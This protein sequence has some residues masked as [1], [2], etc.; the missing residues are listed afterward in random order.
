MKRSD[1]SIAILDHYGQPLLEDTYKPLSIATTVISP[2]VAY[3][4]GIPPIRLGDSTTGADV[5]GQLRGGR[6]GGLIEL[7]DQSLPRFQAQLD[8]FSQ[9]LSE[10]F[11]TAGLTLFTDINGVVPADLPTTASIGYANQ[12]Q[13]SQTIRDDPRLLRDGDDATSAECRRQHAAAQHRR[14]RP[15][16][17][18]NVPDRRPGPNSNLTSSLPASTDFASFATEL[19][20]YQVNEK[21]NATSQLQ[22]ATSL[23]DRLKTKL[24]DQSG[25]NLD[26]E[27]SLLIQ[28]QRS[29]SSSAQVVSTNRQMF[30]D[31]ISI[32]R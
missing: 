2:Q 8:E 31:L 17:R 21:A 23:R 19:V 13:V 3:P 9:T 6:L 15:G 22:S 12:M 26:T 24:S 18:P 20:S 7:R 11:S 14:R 25:V 1:G 32:V 28:L 30:N 4:G 16:K 27:V 10:T 29:Y 5:T